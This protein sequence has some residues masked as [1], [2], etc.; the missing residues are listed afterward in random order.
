MKFENEMI[1]INIRDN[2]YLCDMKPDM[3]DQIRLSIMAARECG[4]VAMEEL[5]DDFKIRVLYMKGVGSILQMGWDELT[6]LM[7][8]MVQIA[9]KE[10]R[11]YNSK[12]I[13]EILKALTCALEMVLGTA[14]HE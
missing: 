1:V 6:Y 10:M 14:V 3:Y 8:V 9:T 7:A 5:A 2:I 12:L 13:H 11:A 4:F